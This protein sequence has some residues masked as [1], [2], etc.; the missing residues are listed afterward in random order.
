MDS[1]LSQVPECRNYILEVLKDLKTPVFTNCPDGS[2]FDVR[3]EIY[4]DGS[5]G[6]VAVYGWTNAVWTPL[7]IQEIK[8]SQFPKWPDTMHSIIG[9]DYFTMWI[10][11]GVYPLTLGPG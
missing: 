5:I 10:K 1:R 4:H 3:I 9:Q 11:T 6:N 8:T 2:S 7:Y